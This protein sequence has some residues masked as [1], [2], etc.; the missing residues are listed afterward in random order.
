VT[1]SGSA[2]VA[3]RYATTTSAVCPAHLA[4][5]HADDHATIQDRKCRLSG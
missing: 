1:E 5:P 3:A 2:L 4:I